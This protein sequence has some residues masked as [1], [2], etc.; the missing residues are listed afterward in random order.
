MSLDTSE[1]KTGG[2][3]PK[4]IVPGMTTVRINSVEL[5]Q[6]P[7]AVAEK[8]YFF[9]L[10]VETKPIE[11]F[12]GFMVDKEDPSK[13][14]Y[15]GQIG[16]VKTNPWFYKD[17]VTK[18]GVK[19]QRDVEIM[20]QLKHICA[21][22]GSPMD[23]KAETIEEMV[24]AFN[25]AKPYADKW[26]D[27]CVGGKEFARDNGFIGYDLF[28]PKMNQQKVVMEI[29]GTTPSK[30]LAYD[31]AVHLVK[32]KEKPVASFGGDLD[33]AAAPAAEKPESAFDI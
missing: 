18:G 20:K 3:L 1:V 22:V 2:A 11:G 23:F 14:N 33:D 10:N 24:A 27:M 28:L 9:V 17:G 12:E 4:T 5:N 6:P 26:L 8:G 30:L 13:G 19:I 32:M 15:A 16:R 31:E 29:S 21:A 25:E 7:F